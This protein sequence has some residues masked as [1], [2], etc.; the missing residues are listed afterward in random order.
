MQLV[1]RTSQVLRKS[2]EVRIQELQQGAEGVLIAAVGSRRDEDQMPVGIRCQSGHEP[3]PLMAA[4][5]SLATPCAGMRLIHDNEFRARTQELL[6]S[7]LRL[8]EVGGD[9]HERM[10]IKERLPEA[11]VPLQP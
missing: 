2:S 8:D 7:S 3:V 9:D 6:Q 11:A 10:E 5:A 4:A 1:F